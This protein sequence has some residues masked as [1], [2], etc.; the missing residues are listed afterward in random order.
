MTSD[1][2]ILAYR[3]R[4]FIESLMKPKKKSFKEL[5]R[6]EAIDFTRT[7]SKGKNIVLPTGKIWPTEK[8]YYVSVN[9]KGSGRFP[10]DE[11]NYD[12]FKNLELKDGD[13]V[14]F[15]RDEVVN[16]GE[17]VNS[18]SNIVFE[19]YGTGNDHAWR[20]SS[21]IS[22]LTWTN[23]GS[24]VYSTPMS[25][26]L[27]VTINDRCAKNAETA[28]LTIQ[29]RADTTHVTVTHANVSGYTNIVGSYLVMKVKNFRSSQRVTVTA[30][31]GAGS[32]TIDDPIDTSLNVDFVLYNKREF[33]SGN[34][35]WAWED[36]TLYVK[37]AASPSTMNIRIIDKAFGISTTGS[38]TIRNMEFAEHYSYAVHSDGGVIDVNN[39]NIH[40]IRD[41]AVFIERQ[42]TGANVSDNIIDRTGNVGL[43]MRP[44]INSTFNRNNGEDI[45]MQINYGWQ[46]FSAG[47]ASSIAP[48]GTQ[49]SGAFITYLIDLEDDAVDGSG[50]EFNDNYAINIAYNGVAA[51][52]GTNHKILRNTVINATQRFEDGSC[53]YIFHYRGY[54]VLQEDT[55][56]AYNICIG[57]GADYGIYLDNRTSGINVHHNV[58]SGFL[59]GMLFNTDTNDHIIEDNISVNSTY[60]YAF[61]TGDNGTLLIATNE[62]NTFNRN[63]A[64]AYSG[65]ECMIFDILG[66]EAGWNP[67]N[68]GGAGNNMYVATTST[69][70][71]SENEGS[72]LTLAGL[73]AAYSQDVASGS[74]IESSRIFVYNATSS[75]V[76]GSAGAG[77]ETFAGVETDNYTIPAHGAV[78]LF[79][80]PV[81]PFINNSLELISA[82]SQYVNFG[83]TADIQFTHTST[84]TVSFW[85][86]VAVNPSQT[87]TF[88]DN[89]NGSGR[90]WCVQM[91]TAG[92][93]QI[94]FVNTTGT[95]RYQQIGTIDYANGQWHHLALYKP[96]PHTS[97][98]IKINNVEETVTEPD[99]LSATIA[100]T[101]DLLVGANNILTI[102]ADV[103]MCNLAIWSTN[104]N[105]N[106]GLI[107]N[108][109]VTMDYMTLA[110]EPIHY[111]PLDGD[112]LDTGS[113]VNKLNGTAINSPAYTAD[114]P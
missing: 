77:Y 51:N 100:S 57:D 55:E 3:K 96:S 50:C 41:M 45:G 46:T 39:C 53:V 60:C 12:Q 36:G 5:C 90:G 43:M 48:G 61:R 98:L 81:G 59:W 49:V 69:I 109:G 78:V 6:R 26:P 92:V 104:E 13:R 88:V 15:K 99:N 91:T 40:D 65:Q 22:T 71:D 94:Q 103:E 89:R 34:N 106:S 112:L 8:G 83:T 29:G 38:M 80:I 97:T 72:N 87:I 52:V 1:K 18:K 84:F 93:I 85:F 27:W 25:E 9:G 74:R 47:P 107:Y 10:N 110:N 14:Y 70:A 42:L 56:I 108:G 111:W 16:V 21:D 68:G 102:F 54:N 95:N 37:A 67:Y 63:M 76:G 20:G 33:L 23:E 86:K 114:V 11:L 30:Y 101:G 75:P 35:E 113:S 79:P 28:R 4:K 64:V 58:C 73:Q 66:T 2:I 17:Y 44:C 105:I 19:S 7:H 31:N 82:S 32:I 24:G 62:G